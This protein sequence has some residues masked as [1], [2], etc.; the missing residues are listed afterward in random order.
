MDGVLSSSSTIVSVKTGKGKA[1]ICLVLTCLVKY[2]PVKS[3]RKCAEISTTRNPL[4][5]PPTQTVTGYPFR[6]RG[7]GWTKKFKVE[8][9]KMGNSGLYLSVHIAYSPPPLSKNNLFLSAE[10]Q[11][12]TSLFLRLFFIL[13]HV[14]TLPA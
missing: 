2:C 3:V 13:L 8:S 7:G 4:P 11:V 9:E 6:V 10:G 1:E 12:S 5:P 14:F